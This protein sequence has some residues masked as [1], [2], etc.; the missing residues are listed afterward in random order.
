[1]K[2]ILQLGA[3][4]VV[5]LGL[6]VGGFAQAQ[7]NLTLVTA[8]ASNVTPT[9]AV[10][11]G[12][13]AV[14]SGGDRNDRPQTFF[15]YGLTT[16]FGQSTTPRSHSRFQDFV[17]VE[18][19]GLLPNQTYYARLVAQNRNG[20][21]Y[22]S[23]VTFVTPVDPNVVSPGGNGGTNIT[24][25]EAPDGNPSSGSTG[26]SGTDTGGDSSGGSS[27]ND[28]TNTDNTN[29]GSSGSGNTSTAVSAYMAL[30]I[31]DD[32]EFFTVGDILTYEVDYR[33]V[34]QTDIEDVFIRIELPD[35]AE[36]L[37]AGEGVYLRREHAVVY[38]IGRLDIGEAGD[39]VA[40][41]RAVNALR[42]G[43]RVAAAA[44]VLY[45]NPTNDSQD[46]AV[47]YDINEYDADGTPVGG[48]SNRRGFLPGSFLGWMLI[49][50]LLLVI[51]LIG[52]KIYL[53]HKEQK[54]QEQ[55]ELELQDV[56]RREFKSD[57]EQDDQTKSAIENAP[58][59]IDDIEP[60]VAMEDASAQDPLND[61]E[62]DPWSYQEKAEEQALDQKKKDFLDNLP[63]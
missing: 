35:N 61:N 42:E 62:E 44:V 19:T 17:N 43:T 52:R 33:N 29:S 22:G 48:T 34:S 41:V 40:S 37:S 46:S 20:L 39:V 16:S 11:N 51:V 7:T 59:S 10:L 36:F 21:V 55:A 63:S 58:S 53:R 13:Y 15:Q 4:V 47:V 1:M 14:N 25:I 9:S 26:G 8:G 38:D 12:S 60:Q 45:A 24:I 27:G 56:I 2:R 57:I 54:E 32:R 23:T 18:V 49:L 5:T 31:D 50:I 3:V 28:T 30:D 6:L